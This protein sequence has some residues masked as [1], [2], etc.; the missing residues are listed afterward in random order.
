MK[1]ILWR[2][3]VEPIEPVKQSEG[4]IELP[5]E[6]L[7]AIEKMAFVG[8]VLALGS[9]AYKAKPREG[10]DYQLETHAPQVGDYVVYGRHSGQRVE[11]RNGRLTVILNDTDVLAVLDSAQEAK[12]IVSYV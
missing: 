4:G 12:E 2:L 3:T 11:N 9:L 8:K 10:L 7:D 6:V 5:P 1:P